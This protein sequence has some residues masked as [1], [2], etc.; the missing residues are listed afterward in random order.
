MNY[1]KWNY[2]SNGYNGGSAGGSGGGGIGIDSATQNPVAKQQQHRNYFHAEHSI[3]IK[4]M[5]PNL[6]ITVTIH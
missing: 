4:Y 5:S 2:K 6:H 3:P 1:L